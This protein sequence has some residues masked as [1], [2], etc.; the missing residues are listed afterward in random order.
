MLQADGH[1]PLFVIFKK[2]AFYV[3]KWFANYIKSALAKTSQLAPR[4]PLTLH[5]LNLNHTFQIFSLCT[6]S[7]CTLFSLI[8]CRLHEA[9]GPNGAPLIVIRCAEQG[10]VAVYK[11]QIGENNCTLFTVPA[12]QDVNVLDVTVSA[13]I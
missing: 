3:E 5:L 1:G 10:S 12:V 7:S 2:L 9:G 4:T 8:K 11:K 13:E 6:L